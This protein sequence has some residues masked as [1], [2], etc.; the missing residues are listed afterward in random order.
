M[1]P[2]MSDDAVSVLEP[3]QQS[4]AWDSAGTVPAVRG[5][6]SDEIALDEIERILIG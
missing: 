3:D 2:R 6:T 5:R 4:V 1:V